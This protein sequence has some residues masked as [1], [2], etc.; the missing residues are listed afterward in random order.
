MAKS[1]AEINEVMAGAADAIS[2]ADDHY[3]SYETF[4]VRF[5]EHAINPDRIHEA[6]SE[7]VGKSIEFGPKTIGP[8]RLA[9]ITAAGRVGEMTVIRCF[10]DTVT[11]RLL[12]P[13]NLDL[14]VRVAGQ[15]HRFHAELRAGLTLT[16]R[17]AEPLHLIIDV[18]PPSAA[19]VQVAVRAKGLRA[20][21]L[22]AAAN[23]DGELRRFVARYIGKEIEK[24]YLKRVREIDIAEYISKAWD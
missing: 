6:M 14:T 23:V 1:V 19:D 18:A 12:I 24:P 9:R 11:Y 13:V 5:F 16:A 17:A 10:D 21:L 7:L 8:A 20:R 22:R 4:G 2:A 15:N 3:C